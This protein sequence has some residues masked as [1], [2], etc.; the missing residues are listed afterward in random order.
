LTPTRLELAD[1]AP[2]SVRR[3]RLQA[4]EGRGAEDTL[5]G[6]TLRSRDAKRAAEL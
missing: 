3:S 2:S 5:A 1:A 6:A 4:V